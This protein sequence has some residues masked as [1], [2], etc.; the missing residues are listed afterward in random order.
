MLPP[1]SVGR[2]G[3]F[4][5]PKGVADY[6]GRGAAAAA[7][8][9]CGQGA[10]AERA[11]FQRLEKIAADPDALGVACFATA[12]QVELSFARRP[13]KHAGKNSLMIAD[14]LPLRVGNI[15]VA[16]MDA[17]GIPGAVKDAHVGELLG[18]RDRQRS[19]AERIDQLEDGGVC[20]SAQRERKH[21]N[22]GE[23]RRFAQHAQA[24]AQ[25]LR[26]ILQPSDA[27]N[28]ATLLFPLLDSAHFDECLSMRFV[29]DYTFR[30]V[31]L[32]LSLDVIAQLVVQF[33]VRLR[34]A[35]QRPQPQGNC[36]QP[37]FRSHRRLLSALATLTPLLA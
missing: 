23:K 19:Q 7:V 20:A 28:I 30:D 12:G 14:L 29:W 35:K 1:E 27:A 21:G 18:V 32:S 4:A 37:V 11:D 2:P 16:A 33:L 22:G 26:E 13:C 24:E 17:A 15:G 5:L 36:V 6:G 34:S 9:V 3:V 25:V 10:A 8:I 31:L